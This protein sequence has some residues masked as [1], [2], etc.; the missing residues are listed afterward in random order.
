MDQTRK[1]GRSPPSRGPGFVQPGEKQS[2]ATSEAKP[3]FLH[4][5]QTPRRTL[6]WP[7]LGYSCGCSSPRPPSQ[8]VQEPRG[9]LWARRRAGWHGRQ[10]G[11]PAPDPDPSR[12][13]LQQRKWRLTFRWHPKACQPRSHATSSVPCETVTGDSRTPT[14]TR[15]SRCRR[16]GT[17]VVTGPLPQLRARGRS[18]PGPRSA[19]LAASQGTRC[20]PGQGPL[21]P[22][23]SAPSPIGTA[24]VSATSRP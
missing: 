14:A 1:W 3:R 16:G 15:V 18:W 20:R 19:S 17:P 21:H 8:A 12:A 7:P 9:P 6:V 5:R 13:S 24:E 11:S 22:A 23:R 4:L 10:L 2:D